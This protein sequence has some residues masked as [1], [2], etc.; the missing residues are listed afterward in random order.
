MSSSV[1]RSIRVVRGGCWLYGRQNAWVDKRGVSV[2]GS[3]S[4]MES[5]EFS[6][7]LRLMRRVPCA[8]GLR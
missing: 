5:R 4:V 7:G 6:Q 3:C 8:S 2:R 1:L